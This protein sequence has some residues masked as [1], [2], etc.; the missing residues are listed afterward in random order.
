MEERPTEDT[1]AIVDSKA[2]TRAINEHSAVVGRNTDVNNQKKAAL[3]M[4]IIMFVVAT[5]SLAGSWDTSR[6]L[7]EY[8][9]CQAEWNKFLHTALNA[10][11]NAGAEATLAMDELINAISESRSPEQS[12][13][14]LTKYKEARAK[15]IQTQQE[16]PLPPAPDEV[17]EI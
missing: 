7:T 14:A 11:T 13:A 8:V 9:Q 6:K 3:I 12:R 17:C 5:L 16:H 1:Q 10:R 4:A 15:Q 2:Q